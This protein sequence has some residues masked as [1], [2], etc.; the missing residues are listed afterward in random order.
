MLAGWTALTVAAVLLWVNLVASLRASPTGL[1]LPAR[2]LV[3]AHGCLVLGLAVALVGALVGHGTSQP[4]GSAR[5]ALAVLL[6]PGWLG[7]TV[8][9][10]LLHLL[11]VLVRVRDFRQSLPTSAPVRALVGIALAGVLGLAIARSHGLA[12]LD[13]AATGALLAAYL[14]LGAMVI[15]PPLAPFVPGLQISGFDEARSRAGLALA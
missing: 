10:S 4:L 12:V 14:V 2:L 8:L 6:L 3:A 11:A 15:A 7:L 5:V 13:V 9:G 1:S